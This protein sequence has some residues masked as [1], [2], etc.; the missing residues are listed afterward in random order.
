MT[1][2]PRFLRPVKAPAANVGLAV[3]FDA[4]LRLD[5]GRDLSPFTVAYT[6]YGTLNAAKSNAILICHFFSGNSHAAGKYAA[7]DA[8]PGYW[9]AI[10]GPGKA[11]DT[12]KY[13]VIASDTL[14]NLNTGDPKVTTTGPAW[15]AAATANALAAGVRP[16][17]RLAGAANPVVAA[18]SLSRNRSEREEPDVP[19]MAERDSITE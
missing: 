19:G 4:P 15:A 3:T 7:A 2:A 8:A 1:E 18:A 12:N 16:D 9:D 14:V 10:I 6:T 11:I 5:C 17:R 13:F